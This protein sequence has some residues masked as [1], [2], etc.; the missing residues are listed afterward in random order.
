M[1]KTLYLLIILASF[2]NCGFSQDST[3]SNLSFNMRLRYDS[4][5]VE[6]NNYE[7]KHGGFIQTRNI[8]MHYLEWG[9]P[10]NT[11]LIWVHGSFTNSYELLNIAED[12]VKEGYYVIAI[13]Y[14][15]HGLTKMPTHEVSLYHV[16]DDIKVLMEVKKIKKAIIG[17]WSRGGIIATA[18]YDA[19]PNKVLGLILEDGGS[20]STNTHYHKFEEQEL[21]SRVKNIFKDRVSYSMFNSEYEAYKTYYDYNSGGTQFE[22]LA[23]LT[24]DDIGKWSIGTGIE[25]LFNMSNEGQF[26]DN[27]LRPTKSSL[28]GESMSIIEPKIVYRNLQ[29]PILILD[30]V[31]DQDIFPYEKENEKL[32]SQHPDLITY[33]IYENTGHNI[34]YEKPGMFGNDLGSFLKVVKKHSTNKTLPPTGVKKKNGIA[35]K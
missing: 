21:S 7:K 19:Y 22:L 12:L 8:K 17:G 29:V 6:F 10:K 3:F 32:K 25:N 20:V 11:P 13:D 26:L 9:N 35:F 2:V 16:A 5:K 15:G 27:I 34:H 1:I 33:K 4:A 23:W 18:F 28:F 14:Y 30:P 31:S 24:R